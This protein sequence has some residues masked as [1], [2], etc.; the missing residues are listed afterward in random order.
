MSIGVPC[1]QREPLTPPSLPAA[2][3]TR[4]KII[5]LQ[6]WRSQCRYHLYLT[7]IPAK[8]TDTG[9]D[10]LAPPRPLRPPTTTLLLPGTQPQTDRTH[11]PTA[12]MPAPTALLKKPADEPV[13]EVP[14]AE[15]DLDEND[16]LLDLTAMNSLD[17]PLQPPSA[18]GTG[19][20][21][22]EESRPR[23]APAKDAG[24]AV[25]IETRK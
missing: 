1:R 7:L 15:A 13:A 2:F 23:F 12:T 4:K 18:A 9:L 16:V 14:V 17:T 10:L 6:P 19:M 25:R 11:V 5:H 3:S 22:D 21:I 20:E 8:H 24:P